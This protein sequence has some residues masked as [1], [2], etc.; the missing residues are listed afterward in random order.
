MKFD[1]RISYSYQPNTKFLADGWEVISFTS[2]DG[3]DGFA[4]LYRK[5]LGD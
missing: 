1:Y 3:M 4:F 2:V 5:Q